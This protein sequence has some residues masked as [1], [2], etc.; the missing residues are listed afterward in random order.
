M[1]VERAGVESVGCREVELA[2][3]IEI[4]LQKVEDA[5]EARQEIMLVLLMCCTVVAA[6]SS[7][8]ISMTTPCRH[9]KGIGQGMS[10]AASATFIV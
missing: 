3:R 6:L 5:R 8:A 4:K 2:T 9:R 10:I 7:L 1:S